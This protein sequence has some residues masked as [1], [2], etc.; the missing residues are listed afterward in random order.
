MA[1]LR[2]RYH[3]LEFGDHDIHFR[4]LRDRQQYNDD[5][6]EAEL[7]GISST[8]WPIA[9]MVWPSEEVLALLMVNYPTGNRRVLEVGCGIGLASL[10]LNERLADISATDIHPS[11]GDN[12]QH[13]TQ[14][15]NARHI[16]FYRT[17]WQDNP[18]ERMGTFDLII[19]SDLLYESQHAKQLTLF[20]QQTAKPKCEVI[21]VDASRGHSP[22]FRLRMQEL[23]FDCIQLDD[24]LPVTNPEKYK[25]RIF[26]FRRNFR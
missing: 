10:V 16:P 7:L 24:I 22:K 26:R 20:L 23:G 12:L 3:T 19:G 11:S 8:S 2:Y 9:G 15:N 13:N 5:L 17:A 14:L 4:A 6:G 18:A 21:L 1:E 25:G